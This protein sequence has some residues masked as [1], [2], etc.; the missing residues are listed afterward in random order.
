M[1]K[2]P[3]NYYLNENVVEIAKDLLGKIICTQ[4]DNEITAGIIAE[5]EA[6]NGIKDKACHAYKGK[7]TQRTEIMYNNGGVAYIYL[8]Y[9]IHHLINI[10]TSNELEPKAV[11]IRAIVPLKGVDTML[12][13]R[14][15]IKFTI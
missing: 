11:L 12:K 6:Y 14:R 5:T 2:I 10:V 13:R 15:K 8:C 9:G 4:V 1:I 3:I 7:R